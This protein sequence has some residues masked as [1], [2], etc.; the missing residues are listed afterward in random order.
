M[1]TRI[2]TQVCKFLE[3]ISRWGVLPS[4]A[5]TPSQ[6]VLLASISFH[7]A[8]LPTCLPNP[9]LSSSPLCSPFPPHSPAFLPWLACMVLP[10]RCH[11]D[12]CLFRSGVSKLFFFEKIQLGNIVGFV[13]C[14]CCNTH[15]CCCSRKTGKDNTLANGCVPIKLSFQNQVVPVLGPQSGLRT[16]FRAWRVADMMDKNNFL[17]CNPLDHTLYQLN[18]F[19]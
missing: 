1:H 11:M 17:L 5:W 8:S 15:L 6:A 10:S 13:C 19:S 16:L 18:C 14:L 2:C 9:F 3:I 7:A 4:E 12:F